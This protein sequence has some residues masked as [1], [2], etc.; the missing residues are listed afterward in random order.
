MLIGAFAGLIS[1][2]DGTSYRFRGV[3]LAIL[4]AKRRG[5][6]SYSISSAFQE[7]PVTFEGVTILKTGL[8]SMRGFTFL[9]T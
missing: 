8:A 2:A 5:S 7:E 6:L 1:K 9:L 4:A 3:C